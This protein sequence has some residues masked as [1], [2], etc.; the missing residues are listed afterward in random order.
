[1]PL[2]FEILK[3]AA[4]RFQGPSEKRPPFTKNDRVLG[5]FPKNDREWIP[6]ICSTLSEKHPAYPK[7]ACIF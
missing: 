3:M 6:A 2:A 5:N 4:V 7:Y 1:M